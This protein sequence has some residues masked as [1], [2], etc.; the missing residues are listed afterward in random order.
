MGELDSV[1]S[2]N[3]N[4]L[5]IISN[6]SNQTEFWV[7]NLDGSGLKQISNFSKVV[8]IDH[9]LRVSPDGKQLAF[10]GSD[11]EVAKYATE[12]YLIN[13]DGTGLKNN[14]HTLGAEEWL[15]W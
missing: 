2:P 6:R 8:S 10:Y 5:Y 15:D 13:V 11:Q 14:S 7:I 1:W 9:S 12:I 4:K 3:G